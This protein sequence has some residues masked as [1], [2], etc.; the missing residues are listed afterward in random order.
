MGWVE[1]GVGDG[2]G[3]VAGGGLYLPI[4]PFGASISPRSANYRS[5]QAWRV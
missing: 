5:R 2:G 1:G 4:G 3:W